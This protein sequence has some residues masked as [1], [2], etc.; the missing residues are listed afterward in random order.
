MKNGIN[1][2]RFFRN[3]STKDDDVLNE[4]GKYSLNLNKYQIKEIIR[5][6]NYFN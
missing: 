5:F 6:Y 2:E 4:T 3:Y 1:I